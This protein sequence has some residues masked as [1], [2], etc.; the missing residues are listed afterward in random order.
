[1]TVASADGGREITGD[2][3]VGGK[4]VLNFEDYQPDENLDIITCS[5][6]LSQ[7]DEIE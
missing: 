6:V 5:N 7:F 1:M 2:A 3:S 4:L